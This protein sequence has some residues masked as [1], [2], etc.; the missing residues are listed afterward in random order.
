MSRL[1]KDWGFALVVAAAVYTIASWFRGRGPDVVGEAPAIY[2]KDLDGATVDLAALRGQTVVLNFWASWCGP[3][4]AEMPEFKQ[5]AADHPDVK[6][7]GVAVDSGDA[8]EVRDAA[9]RLGITWPV[10]LATSKMSRDYDI[11][12][13]PTTY[14]L[15]PEG[16][17]RSSHAGAMRARDLAAAVR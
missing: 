8:A 7:I 5:F 16:T 2:A 13:L 17:V 14:V 6:L 12:V 1:L 3:C 9:D 15:T 11:S 4:R 10:I